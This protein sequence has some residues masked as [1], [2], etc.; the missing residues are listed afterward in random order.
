MGSDSAIDVPPALQWSVPVEVPIGNGPWSSPTLNAAENEMF[1]ESAGGAV[2]RTTFEGTAW[3]M[4]VIVQGLQAPAGKHNTSPMLSRDELAMYFGT[5]RMNTGNIPDVWRVPRSDPTTPV[6]LNVQ[7][8]PLVPLN[9]DASNEN[10]GSL[11]T[12]NDLILFTSDRD[13]HASIYQSLLSN[14]TWG[15]PTKVVELDSA[16]ND[17]SHASITGDG[18]TVV[19]ASNRNGADYDIY[20][21]SRIDKSA[22]FFAPEPIPVMAL[23]ATLEVD[24]WISAD[25]DVIYFARGA[26][27]NRKIFRSMRL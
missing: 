1:L 19:F 23:P 22:P 25:G 18:L 13:G 4:P 3:G 2:Y 6:F 10:G 8:A 17:D 7:A 20:I 14:G 9:A 5:D 16:N 21:A 15:A 26:A 27:A 24:P 11:T 12:G